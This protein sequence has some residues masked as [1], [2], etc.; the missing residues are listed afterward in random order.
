MKKFNHKLLI[1]L[2]C[3]LTG[4]ALAADQYLTTA[5]GAEYKD[6]KAGE[7]ESAQLGDIA[8]IHFIGW[9]DANGSQGKEL[10][11]S[12]KQQRPV[13]FVVGT[14]KVM[15]GWNEGVIGM[16]AGGK[17]MLRVPPTLG[18]GARA[19]PDSVPENS[20]LIFVIDLV[21]LEKSRQ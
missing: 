5:R 13:S 9:I 15:A 3:L 20:S 16:R 10:Y 4:Q 1:I 17:R 14:D 7:G 19:V 18:Y 2:C 11:N 12:R 6:L 8:T 21:E